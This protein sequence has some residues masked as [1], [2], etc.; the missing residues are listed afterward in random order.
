MKIKTLIVDDEPHARRY[1]SNLLLEDTVIELVG[2][3]KNGREA[4]D[5]MI[6]EKV[7]LVFLDI[8]MPGING[9][10]VVQQLPKGIKS[11]IVFTTAYDQYAINAFEDS[12]LDYLLKP[13][14]NERLKKTLERVK[15]QLKLQEQ[16][17][18]HQKITRLYE[19]F[20]DE[21]SPKLTEFIIKIRGFEKVVKCK[22][23][24]WI[25]SSSVYIEIHTKEG[26]DLYRASL[27][28]LENDLPKEFIRVHR[29][30]ILNKE[31]ISKAVY[32]GNNT[33]KFHMKDGS[34]LSSSRSYKPSIM[35]ALST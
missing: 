19:D 11:F 2:A 14:D 29:S 26:K 30:I 35:K 13:F 5:F 7:D 23:I 34:I 24:I 28:Q 10:E 31:Q 27:N 12:A 4:V 9:L 16:A 1:L 32:Q 33:Y 25:S 3:L 8:H 6:R 21:R 17:K 20:Q 22:D 18:L 15:Q